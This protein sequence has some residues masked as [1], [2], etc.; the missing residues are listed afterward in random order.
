MG[1]TA[2]GVDVQISLTRDDVRALIAD[3]ENAESSW[4]PKDAHPNPSMDFRKGL[5]ELINR[6]SSDDGTPD[7]VLADFLH[8]CLKA[9]N[10]AVATRDE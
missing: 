1:M 4:E 9:F 3:L 7:H 5:E 10:K 8:E 2:G 6:H